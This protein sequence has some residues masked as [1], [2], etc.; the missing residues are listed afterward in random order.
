MARKKK[1][2]KQLIEEEAL[3]LWSQ[4]VLRKG[5]YRCLVCGKEAVHSHHFIFK[6][7]S[8]VLR[9]DV[10]NGIPLCRECHASIHF[11]QDPITIGI[12]TNKK[13]REWLRYIEIRKRIKG[14]TK[15]KKWTE[16]Q[17]R[18]LKSIPI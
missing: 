17:L 8:L 14:I 5:N 16:E 9:F 6:S 1:T 3:K 11:R 2:E 15:T 12:I 10:R 7:Q 13:G 4:I 18:I